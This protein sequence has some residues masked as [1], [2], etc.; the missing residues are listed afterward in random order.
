MP[1]DPQ[2]TKKAPVWVEADKLGCLAEELNTL[3]AEVVNRLSAVLL[4]AMPTE[5][6]VS[7]EPCHVPLAQQLADT[8]ILLVGCR[9]TLNSLL[10]RLAL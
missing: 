4:P 5:D 9:D 8:K 3:L 6:Q 10:N 7:E 1:A 2:C